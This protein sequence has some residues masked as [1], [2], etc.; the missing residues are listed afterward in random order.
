MA[1][2]GRQTW[3]SAFPTAQP[4][5]YSLDDLAQ[6]EWGFGT[7]IP[8]AGNSGIVPE[9]RAMEMLGASALAFDIALGY[10]YGF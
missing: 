3:V 6:Q 10:A 1:P 2:V 7:M 8:F 4:V 5:L 9:V